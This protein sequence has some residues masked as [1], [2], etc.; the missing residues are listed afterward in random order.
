MKQ[1]P[2]NSLCMNDQ[3]EICVDMEGE[4]CN[5]ETI[6]EQEKLHNEPRR[7][8]HRHEPRRIAHRHEPRE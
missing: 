5:L 4:L 7:I 1:I 3:G 2:D 8:A 6:E